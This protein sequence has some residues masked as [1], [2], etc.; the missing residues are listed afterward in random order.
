MG[1]SWAILNFSLELVS[2]PLL[3]T[4]MFVGAIDIVLLVEALY[5]EGVPSVLSM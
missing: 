2:V 3:G 4:G 1:P 5:G